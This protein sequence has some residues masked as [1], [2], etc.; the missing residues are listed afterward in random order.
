MFNFKEKKVHKEERLTEDGT[1][2]AREEET[3]NFKKQL[4]ATLTSSL[5]VDF[6]PHGDM[7]EPRA[8]FDFHVAR[9]DVRCQN[10]RHHAVTVIVSWEDLEMKK[11]DKKL[12]ISCAR[13]VTTSR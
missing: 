12:S 2:R 1:K 10:V 5:S 3:R 7:S 8:R 6:K 4:T 9:V 13:F 11:I